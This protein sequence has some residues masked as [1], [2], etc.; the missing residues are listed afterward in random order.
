MINFISKHFFFLFLIIVIVFFF[1]KTLNGLLPIPSDTIVGL[2]HPFRD[3][4]AKEYPNGIP[5]KNFLITDPVRQIYP[6]KELSIDLLSN[7][8]VPSWNPYEMAGKPLAGNFQSSLFYPLN[9]ILLFNPFYLSWSLF[10]I[11]Q[12]VL[13][14][15][16]MFAFLRN[17]S[18]QMRDPASAGKLQKSASVLG[19]LAFSFSGFVISWFEWGNVIHTALWLP[20]ILLSIDKMFEHSNNK[21][22]LPAGRQGK[23]ILIWFAILLFSTISSF[24][25]GHLQIFFYVSI[26][27]FAYFCLRW[28]Q[29][30][31]K[32]K[33]LGLFVISFLLFSI[34][35]AVQWIPT[36][37]FINLSARGLDLNWHTEGWFIPWQHLIQFIFP[38]FF[39][40]PATLNYFGVWNYA[41]FVGYI[42]IIP[43]LFAVY[44][45]FLSKLKEKYFFLGGAV[46][47]LTFSLPTPIAEIPFKLGI[48]L[49]SSSQ[50]TRLIFI[51][52]FCS[53]VLGAIGFDHFQKN[54]KR[55]LKQ[56][57]PIALLF[58]LF[59]LV[60]ITNYKSI[61]LFNLNLQNLSVVNRNLIFP[62]LIFI[63]GSALVFTYLFIKNKTIKNALVILILIIAAF[64]LFRFSDKFAPFTKKEYLFPS[65]KTVEFIKKDKEVFRIG[66]NDSRIFPPNFLTHYKIQ[67]IEGYDPLYLLSY[68]QLIAASERG[69]PNIAPPYGFNRIITPHNLDSKIIDLLNV[70]YIFSLSDINNEK[71]EKVFEEGQTRTYRNVNYSPR[72]FFVERTINRKTN[73]EQ[74]DEMFAQDLLRVAIVDGFD[75]QQKLSIGKAEIKK[76]SENEIIIKTENKGNG[77]L[78]ISDVYYP[79]WE[80]FIDGKKAEVFKTNYALRGILVPKGAH[81]IVFKN[82][83]F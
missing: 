77:F 49:L 12:V 53:A 21:S 20:L 69:E 16:F 1:S 44:S 31:R 43:I 52:S 51:V 25:A 37:Q 10:I 17:L 2:Y 68:G 74:I 30:G 39:G 54:K 14:A 72:A 59:S 4:Y 8:Q 22:N 50:P 57:A 38:D 7:F 67:S 62:T 78:V 60:W 42:G 55:S 47:A 40:N 75:S 29:N 36:L 18:T 83:L 63:L 19:A 46:I 6:W 9:I 56:L 73:Q 32:L 34:I 41:E 61:N 26:F 80:A 24:F 33:T 11:L 64:D 66:S 76:Y 3:I 71:F 45:L 15:I 70:K 65:T 13:T 28:F 79:T 48:P 27:S 35:T 58:L 5:F 23:K 82:R 81:E